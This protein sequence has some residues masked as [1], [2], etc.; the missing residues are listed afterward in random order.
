M[1]FP[2]IFFFVTALVVTLSIISI[3]QTTIS[4]GS[5]NGTVTDPSGAVVV[6]AKVTITNRDTG[7]A[8]ATAT[9]SSGNYTSGTLAP[10][11]YS[12]R[13]ESQGYKTSERLVSV[14]VNTTANG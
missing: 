5:I 10:G 7:Q 14:R 8:I 4:T 6:G 2:R 1:S 12:L 11:N 9:N 13:V 3:A